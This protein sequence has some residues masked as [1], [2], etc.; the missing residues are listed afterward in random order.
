[1]HRTDDFPSIAALFC[2][3]M[4]TPVLVAVLGDDTLS[5][6]LTGRQFTYVTAA[7]FGPVAWAFLSALG[8][9][10]RNFAFA[11]I[12]V[13]W[14]VIFALIPAGIALRP[15]VFEYLFWDVADLGAYAAS[16]M[17]AGVVA[18]AAD[19]AVERRRT[20]Y[21]WVPASRIIAVGIIAVVVFIAVAGVGVLHVTAGS[22]SV[23]DVEPGVLGYRGATL[24]VTVDGDPTELRLRTV[25][26]GG[27]TQTE[28]VPSADFEDGT[29]TV[30]VA[31]HRLGPGDPQAGTYEFELRS[32]AGLTVDT[33][34]YTVE[35]PPPSVLTV[36]T[37]PEFGELALEPDPDTAESRSESRDE[38]WI[39]VVFTHR[40]NVANTFDTRVLAGGEAVADQS[41]F[42]EPGLRG[43]SIFGLSDDAVE[44]IH[45]RADGVATIEVSYKD[46]RVT[47]AVRLPDGADERGQ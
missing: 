16:F 22:A 31:F 36:E 38:V 1:M 20:E 19:R 29:V 43:G 18:V 21:G 15:D 40:G 34:T 44:R 46:H 17:L 9:D 37:A 8:F 3:G 39:G 23:S 41:V 45:N 30:P 28:R 24:N 13:P 7:L 27:V 26:P 14:I 12:A 35:T 5:L 25:T 10:R 4:L 6:Y 47:R 11:S 42:V 33:A 32:V 2:A